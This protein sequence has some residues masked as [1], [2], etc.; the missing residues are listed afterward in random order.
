MDGGGG[1]YSMFLSFVVLLTLLFFSS[2][3]LTSLNREEMEAWLGVE[4]GLD[5]PR[6][7]QWRW[8]HVCVIVW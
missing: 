8:S 5:P 6:F 4:K 2:H 7:E 3:F 1:T